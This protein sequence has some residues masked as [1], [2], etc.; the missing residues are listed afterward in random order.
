M[1][2]MSRRAANDNQPAPAAA[3]LGFRRRFTTPLVLHAATVIALGGLLSIV[4]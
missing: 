1:I 2:E 3:R 4:P